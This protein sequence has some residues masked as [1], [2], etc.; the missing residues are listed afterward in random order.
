LSPSATVSAQFLGATTLPTTSAPKAVRLLAPLI[1]FVLVAAALW[2]WRIPPAG[3][4][5]GTTVRF[6]ASPPGEIAVTSSGDF[7]VGRGLQPGSVAARGGLALANVSARPQSVRIR[8]LPSSAD[9]DDRL[10][11]TLKAG[12]WT[13]VSGRLGDL[14]TWS[15]SAI[16]LPPRTRIA[17]RTEAWLPRSVHD[18]YE[19]REVDV[20]V[21]IKADPIESGT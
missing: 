15:T 12:R 2:S 4:A 18:G 20:T 9:L 13:L 7:A 11:V 6:V 8:A 3:G 17:L 14:R 5:L 21:E 19:A 10:Q 1:G 16:V